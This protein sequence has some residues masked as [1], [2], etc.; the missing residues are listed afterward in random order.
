MHGHMQWIFE[1]V[2][3]VINNVMCMYS[4]IKSHIFTI[5]FEQIMIDV[6]CSSQVSQVFIFFSSNS[7]AEGIELR[8]SFSPTFCSN[9]SNANGWPHILE[10]IFWCILLP[11]KRMKGTLQP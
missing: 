8:V 9:D 7:S 2:Y 3:D 6:E 10:Q 4:Y 5:S 1:Y 11:P